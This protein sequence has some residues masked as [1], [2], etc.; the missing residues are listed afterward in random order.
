MILQILPDVSPYR[1]LFPQPMS[2][3]QFFLQG[4][5]QR[6]HRRIIVVLE[7][8]NLIPSKRKLMLLNLV[9]RTRREIRVILSR[10]QVGMSLQSD[11]KTKQFSAVFAR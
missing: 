3:I 6:C 5:E 7:N 2:V 1:T 11:L 8:E 4:R 9:A 10:G